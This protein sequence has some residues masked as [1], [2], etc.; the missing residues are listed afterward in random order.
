MEMFVLLEAILSVKDEL[1]YVTM[2]C[3]GLYVIMDG[4]ITMLLLYASNWVFKEIVSRP[5]HDML[6]IIDLWV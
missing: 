5:D 2:E 1:R 4:I 6:Y 3:G